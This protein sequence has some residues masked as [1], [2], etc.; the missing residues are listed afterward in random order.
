M[1]VQIEVKH[2]EALKEIAESFIDEVVSNG[3]TDHR[4]WDAIVAAD[5]VIQGTNP[6]SYRE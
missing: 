1:Q 6:E 3:G 5:L 4:V 2:L